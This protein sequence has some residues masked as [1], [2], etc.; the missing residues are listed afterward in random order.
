LHVA[1][2]TFNIPVFGL[3]DWNPY[4]YNIMLTYAHGGREML[5]GYHFAV[6]SL[7]ILGLRFEHIERLNHNIYTYFQPITDQDR[8]L[9]HGI[10]LRYSDSQTA[11]LVEE[12]NHMVRVG[13]KLELEILN[14]LEGRSST[15]LADEWIFDI[16]VQCGII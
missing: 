3:T 1:S 6:P 13:Y 12:M 15:Y 10:S 14:N 4:G 8:S 2:E 16:L 11:N 7:R 9:A 5:E